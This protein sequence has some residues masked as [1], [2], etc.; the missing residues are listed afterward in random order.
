M[1]YADAVDYVESLGKFGIHLG[2]ERIQGLILILQSE[3][4]CH[5]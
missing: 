3:V 5:D 1:E 4:D 2:M